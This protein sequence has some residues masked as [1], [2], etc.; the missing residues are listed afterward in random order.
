MASAEARAG[1]QASAGDASLSSW[2]GTPRDVERQGQLSLSVAA[3][4][5]A[6]IYCA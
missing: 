6:R 4:I 1:Q 3:A 5:A 2:S